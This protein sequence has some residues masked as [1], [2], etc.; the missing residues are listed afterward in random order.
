MGTNILLYGATG[1]SGRLIAAEAKKRKLGRDDATDCRMILAARDPPALR[2]VATK[3]GMDYRVFGLDDTA[4]VVQRLAGV[5]VVL[6]AAGPFAFT[7]ERLAGAAIRARCHYL[8]I[9]GEIDVYR[10]LDDLAQKASNRKIA[11]VSG[12]GAWAGTSD[13]LLSSA[14]E[15]S[16]VKALEELGVKTLEQLGGKTLEESG[17][18]TLE[19]L[20]VKTLEELGVKALG[21]RP[22]GAIRIALSQI[23]DFSRGSAA[24]AARMLR[25]QVLVVRARTVREPEAARA[26]GKAE[27][28]GA[29]GTPKKRSREMVYVHEPVGKIERI[30]NF[31]KRPASRD[32]MAL[33]GRNIASAANMIDTLSAKHTAVRYNVIAQRI[34]TYVQTGPVGRFAYDFAGMASSILTCPYARGL[35]QAQMLLLPE[36]PTKEERRDGRHVVVLEIEDEF[37]SRVI[38]WCLET[39]DVYQL[40]AQIAVAAA[41]NMAGGSFKEV[42]WATPAQGLGSTKILRTDAFDGCKFIRGGVV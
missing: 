41:R 36:G 30:F 18:K 29:V 17:G 15:Q 3:N 16:R 20:G 40:T 23:L 22:L 12:A 6:N 19:Q 32:R 37:H 24:S 9:N 11:L 27:T 2:E 13:V 35:T 25:E 31:G 39:P 5:N 10:K 42:G 1:Y 4:E 28:P 14:L 21:A 8:D 38:D 34:E 7:A 33:R 26:V